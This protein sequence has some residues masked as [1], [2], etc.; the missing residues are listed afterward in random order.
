M[1]C[2]SES[3]LA[4]KQR[5][6]AAYARSQHSVMQAIERVVCGCDFG[7]NS[8]THREQADEPIR[9][10]GIDEG[11]ELIDLGSGTGW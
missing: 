9:M 8:W 10:L 3:E 6:E 5:F 2:C 1:F 4:L 7:G 11:A